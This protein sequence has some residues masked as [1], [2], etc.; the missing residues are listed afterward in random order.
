MTS[1][2]AP[3]TEAKQF[4]ISKIRNKPINA[5]AKASLCCTLKLSGTTTL[6]GECCCMRSIKKELSA[7]PPVIKI[8]WSMV[9]GQLL[10]LSIDH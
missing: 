4:G 9:D 10:L 8:R 2:F 5:M 1:F 3:V 7:P 6:T